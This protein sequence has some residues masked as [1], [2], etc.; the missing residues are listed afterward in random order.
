M[1][2]STGRCPLSSQTELERALW[3]G[4]LTSSNDGPDPEGPEW[5]LGRC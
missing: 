5:D 4:S 3:G 2:I 1:Y